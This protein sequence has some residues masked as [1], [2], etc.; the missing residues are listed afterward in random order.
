MSIIGVTHV[1]LDP[2]AQDVSNTR[3]TI[4]VGFV[5][6][7]ILVYDHLITLADEVRH[8]WNK[9][10]GPLIYL[11][12]LNRYLIP[13]GFIVNLFA[14]LW[15]DWN[16]TSCG[17]FVRYEG[18]MTVIGINVVALIMLLRIHAIYHNNKYVVG[19]V[20]II[21]AIEFG[22]NAWLLSHGQPVRHNDIRHPPCTMVF[23][24]KLKNIASAS[25]WLPLLYDTIVLVFT[26]YRTVMTR[27]MKA[28]GPSI[29]DVL[30]HEGLLYYS[31]ICSIT[32]TLTIMIKVAPPNLQNITA[33]LE[34]LLTVAMMSRI[35]LDLKEQSRKLSTNLGAPRSPL[36]LGSSNGSSSSTMVFQ[37]LNTTETYRSLDVMTVGL[38]QP[39][40][41]NWTREL[42]SIQNRVSPSRPRPKR[43]WSAL[44]LGT[45]NRVRDHGALGASEPV[46]RSNTLDKKDW[47]WVEMTDQPA[48]EVC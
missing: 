16:D 28:F 12:L 33:Q 13:L 29:M 34:L 31:V 8:I 36:E 5:G 41:G 18:S 40:A 38:P 20:G 43:W 32:F 26:F 7:T 46:T 45:V 19:F 27:R 44:T 21:L 42:E 4:T 9:P 25:A 11:F 17:H 15:P 48:L 37:Q 10:K 47:E 3:I 35:T 14:Y 22:V 2:S 30:L 1:D 39:R 23:D 6:F 24:P